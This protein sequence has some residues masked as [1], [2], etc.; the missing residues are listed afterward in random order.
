[1]HPTHLHTNYKTFS[2]I[3]THHS[4]NLTDLL[5]YTPTPPYD[6]NNT[7]VVQTAPL[8]AASHTSHRK[9]TSQQYVT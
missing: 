4:H 2:Q 7:L 5:Y 3:S 6:V 1:M 9:L 8:I